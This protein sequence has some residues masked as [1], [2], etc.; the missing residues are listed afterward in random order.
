MA[1]VLTGEEVQDVVEIVNRHVERADLEQLLYTALDKQLDDYV[2]ADVWRTQV[3]QLVRKANNQGFVV[4]LLKALAESELLP[5]DKRARLAALAA[6]VA[7]RPA[8]EARRAEPEA[9]AEP[10][11]AAGFAT[12]A[13]QWLSVRSNRIL[14]AALLAYAVVLTTIASIPVSASLMVKSSAE[15]RQQAVANGRVS[16]SDTRP[17]YSPPRPGFSIHYGDY[18]YAVNGSGDARLTLSPFQYLGAIVAGRISLN[19]QYPGGGNT[20][21]VQGFSGFS[22]AQ[23]QLEKSSDDPGPSDTMGLLWDEGGHGLA[24]A[25]SA[26]SLVGPAQAAPA[27]GGR[28]FV[29]SV[30]V[31]KSAGSAQVDATL[32]AGGASIPLTALGIDLSSATQAQLPV[33]PGAIAVQNFQSF[34]ALPQPSLA[35]GATITLRTSGSL[36][37]AGYAESFNLPDAMALGKPVELTGSAGGKMVVQLAYPID[38]VFFE[39]QNT[40]AMTDKLTPLVAAAGFATRLNTKSATVPGSYNV[41]YAGAD[42][43]IPALQKVLKVF[44]DNGVDIR[45]VQPRLQLRNGL[46]NQIQIGSS[47][48]AACL[49]PLTAEQRARLLGSEADFDGV[50]SRPGNTC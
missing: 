29:Q 22:I 27:T 31:D 5:P 39:R 40:P 11:P 3:F 26:W 32:S 25:S 37:S 6:S 30:A 48:Q 16:A 8:P 50:A 44:L 38:V 12:R 34:F 43:P 1:G 46:Q 28:L 20:P 13:A 19:V 15:Q 4:E 42:V 41:V 36:F 45:S 14:V 24:A 7:A 33:V 10:G 2:E 17:Q 49:P 35:G 23:I 21:A 9:E 18:Y 47:S